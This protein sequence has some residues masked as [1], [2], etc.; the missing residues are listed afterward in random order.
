MN[1][2]GSLS[3]QK[4][5]ME[6]DGSFLKTNLRRSQSVF[7]HP[8]RSEEPDTKRV[9]PNVTTGGSTPPTVLGD[10]HWKAWIETELRNLRL[11]MERTKQD[12]TD[13]INSLVE[14]EDD[15]DFIDDDCFECSS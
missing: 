9:K 7:K 6:T 1:N 12:L 14:Y 4:P 11:D 5:A 3:I 10:N 15:S 2:E 8:P 13:Q